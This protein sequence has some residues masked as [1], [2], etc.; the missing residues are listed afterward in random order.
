MMFC[1]GQMDGGIDGTDVA[2]LMGWD[3]IGR[4]RELGGWG[5]I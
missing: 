4:E 3:E 5:Q 2:I 1:H